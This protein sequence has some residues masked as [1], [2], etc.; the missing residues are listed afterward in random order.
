MWQDSPILECSLQCYIKNNLKDAACATSSSA[1]YTYNADPAWSNHCGVLWC[2]ENSICSPFLNG[3]SSILKCSDCVLR[4]KKNKTKE[5]FLLQ[6]TDMLYLSPGLLS[7]IR[8]VF[9]DSVIL[10]TTKITFYFLFLRTYSCT[11]WHIRFFL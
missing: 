7:I 4:R 9:I 5:V 6:Y 2:T 10:M 11:L 3:L 8:Q 1:F